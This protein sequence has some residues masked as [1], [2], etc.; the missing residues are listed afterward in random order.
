MGRC[1]L[2]DGEISKNS[3]I[4]IMP[5]I[6]G[7]KF[8]FGKLEPKPAKGFPSNEVR[9]LI[10]E[11]EFVLA[12]CKNKTYLVKDSGDCWEAGSEVDVSFQLGAVIHE[13]KI[14]MSRY[15]PKSS[16]AKVILFDPKGG[17]T[18]IEIPVESIV[19]HL[20]CGARYLIDVSFREINSS[21]EVPHIAFEDSPS[22][23]QH[24]ALLYSTYC[25]AVGGFAFN[26]DPLPQWDEFAADP[27]KKVQAEAWRAVA[28]QSFAVN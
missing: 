5:V 24:A 17:E 4:N 26:G 14:E 18:R 12:K 2:V 1:H 23:E 9:F 21:S 28:K 7:P 6:I 13:I 10:R 19:H 16:I 3:T 20:S 25:Q 15:G 8:V 11:N 22:L 27:K